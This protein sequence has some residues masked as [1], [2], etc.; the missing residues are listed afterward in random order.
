MASY[1]AVRD[2]KLS[3]SSLLISR[4]P[5]RGWDTVLLPLAIGS[6]FDDRGSLRETRSP[7]RICG[8]FSLFGCTVKPGSK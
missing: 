6:F 1:G 4:D 3:R 2:A 5:S 8:S 7:D